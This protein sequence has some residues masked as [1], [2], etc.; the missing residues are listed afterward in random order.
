MRR[1]WWLPAWLF[2]ALLV[3]ACAEPP[4]KEID[5]AQ[6]AID[7]ARMAGADRYA[8]D[9]YNA[10]AGALSRSRAAVSVKDYR[11]ALNH[12][13]DAHSRAQAAANT[14]TD[15]KARLRSEVERAL[16]DLRA[17]LS[18]A[19]ARLTAAEKNRAARKRLGPSSA[20][21][22]SIDK[23]VQEAGAALKA[24]DYLAA[25]AALQ[26]VG[27]RITEVNAQIEKVAAPPIG[28]GRR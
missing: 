17:A 19:H 15:T 16:A 13:L 1:R 5:Q 14:A 24:E 25:Q 4:N 11:L 8:A 26:T 21:L 3:S 12:A 9:D 23:D 2:A 27:A 20:A 22:A 7:A 18:D 10:A 6:S 28:R